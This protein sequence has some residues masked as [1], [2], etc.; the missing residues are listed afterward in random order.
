MQISLFTALTAAKVTPE[1]ATEVVETLE[2]HIAM[3]VEDAN[4]ALEGKI[5]GMNTKIS[6][7]LLISMFILLTGIVAIVVAASTGNLIK[8]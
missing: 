4:K 3:K 6:I 2:R 1:K 7:M 8:P 5:D